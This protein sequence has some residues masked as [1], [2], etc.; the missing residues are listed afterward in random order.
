M[1]R[2]RAYLNRIGKSLD[3]QDRLLSQQPDQGYLHN[4]VVRTDLPY[5]MDKVPGHRYDLYRLR[6]LG[7]AAP[8]L[9]LLHGGGLTGGDKAGCRYHGFEWAKKGYRVYSL[10]YRRIP[11]VGL[12]EQISDVMDALRFFSR[13]AEMLGIDSR[14]VVLCGEGA[15]ALIALYVLAITNNA[16]LQRTFGMRG[17]GFAFRAAGFFSPMTDPASRHLRAGMLLG[18]ERKSPAA[19]YLVEPAMLISRKNL[20]PVF[21]VTS[22]EDEHREE[23]EKLIALLSQCRVRHR[24][25]DFAKIRAHHLG[26]SFA[27]RHPQYWESQE[28]QGLMHNFFL[29]AIVYGGRPMGTIPG[30]FWVHYDER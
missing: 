18:R 28:A 21:V 3:E 30:D 24:V 26:H 1:P 9:F 25:M 22:E 4:L 6:D 11:E 16:A 8:T 12:Y 13:N 23:S 10:N 20:P 15:G 7:E 19:R 29:E 14:Q 2:I 17:A 27:V 5:R